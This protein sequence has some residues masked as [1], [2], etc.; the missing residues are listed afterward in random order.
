[1]LNGAEAPVTAECC[2]Y[3]VPFPIR[4]HKEDAYTPN[5]VSIGP[6]HHNRH[7]RLLNMER[8]KLS[9][10]KSFLQ[11]T[12]T[13]WDCW[14]RYIE[15]LESHVRRC[16]SDTLEFSK[17]ELVK[18]IFVDSS[19][20]L[21]LFCIYHAK[22]WSSEDVCLSKPWLDSMIRL[23]LLLLE[24][25]LPFS[26]LQALF[27]KFF[28]DRSNIPS[29]LKLSF[30]YFGY[31]NRSRLSFHN[32]SIK[33]FTDLVIT[34]YLQHP[35][36]TRPLRHSNEFVTQL[37]SLTELSK[38]GVQIKV[39]SDSTSTCLL[40]LIFSKGVLEIPKLV[41]HDWTEILFRN[42]IALEQCHYPDEAY[43]TD[44]AD[45][46]DFLINTREDVDKLVQKKILINWLEDADSVANM[47]N[48]LC[49]NVTLSSRNSNYNQ[50][51]KE[52]DE[53]Y[54][55]PCNTLKSTLKR[56]YC[57]TPWQAA[58]SFAGIVLLV[59]A[60]VQTVFS[61]LQVMHQ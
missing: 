12:N 52:L 35:P 28:I 18:I 21:E 14:I 10:C 23:D 29:F 49:K 34:F 31:Y 19:F 26:I 47:F 33:P 4:K 44:Y 60:L 56:D 22:V 59:L 53:F 37:P 48:G 16:Y 32:I 20:I 3:R 51:F 11:R 55:N 9:Y 58:V 46:M 30:E 15:G 25:Q 24:N 39:K 54:R 61:I 38:A 40:G 43:I 27:N 2:I 13:T 36:E 5:V 41:V 45:I 1:M 50:I 6:F 8:H 57:K 42:M 17:E 7:P